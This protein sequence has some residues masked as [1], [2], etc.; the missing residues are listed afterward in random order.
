MRR[1]TRQNRGPARVRAPDTRRFV[2][3]RILR[4]AHRESMIK[5]C[6]T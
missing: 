2:M 3:P 6:L 4:T 5:Q 1:P